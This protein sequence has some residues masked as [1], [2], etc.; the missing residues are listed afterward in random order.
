VYV[1]HPATQQLQAI[2][3]K[4]SVSELA[5][6]GAVLPSADTK[7][8]ASSAAG[9]STARREVLL[10]SGVVYFSAKAMLDFLA[11]S[12]QTPLDSVTHS[13][14]DGTHPPACSAV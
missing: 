14:L 6:R 10:D 3:Q 7:S 1:V 11:L 8:F 5:A 12:E 13:G 9:S 2:L 4:A